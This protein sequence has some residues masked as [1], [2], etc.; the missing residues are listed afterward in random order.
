VTDEDWE[1]LGLGQVPER[2]PQ[3]E[4][5]P[6]IVHPKFEQ[7]LMR[8]REVITASDAAAIMGEDPFRR[9]ADVFLQKTGQSEVVET[10]IMRWGKRMEDAIAAGYIASTRRRVHPEPAYELAVHP[11]LPWL[12]A[13]LDRG[14]TLDGYSAEHPALP[15]PEGA[16]GL[17]ALELKLTSDASQWD[18]APPTP[19]Q[20]QI[21][22]QMACT[23]RT[24]G[25]FAAF[26]G[27]FRPVVHFDVVFDA[28]LF[29]LMVPRLEEFHR[30]V[31]RREV[32]TDDPLFFSRAS[33]KQ[34]WP[35]HV[36]GKVI[37]LGGEGEAPETCAAREAVI[38]KVAEWERHRDAEA[39][40]KAE[41]EAA[42]D[43]LKVLMGDAE[44]GI[45]RDGSFLTLKTVPPVPVEAT[46]R[47][48][49]RT[50]RHA[51]PRRRKE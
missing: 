16:V 38:E 1:Q 45:L 48:G 33:I 40:A 31:Q 44:T 10:E 6:A 8:R 43:A 24:W 28:E 34:L 30:Y 26:V 7:W 18:V 50:L 51:F 39:K 37:V 2:V 49:Y 3:F 17:G 5:A 13:T 19:Y 29:D 22:I 23:R 46:V 21:L 25:S 47:S 42:E 27:L 15:G 32:P 9:P 20:V 12:A 41:K 4:A 36:K 35:S 14:V 11:E